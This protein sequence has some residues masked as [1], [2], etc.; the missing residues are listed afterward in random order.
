MKYISNPWM[1]S[2]STTNFDSKRVEND[3]KLRSNRKNVRSIA[4]DY[5]L[6]FT[7]H[8]VHTRQVLSKMVQK[9]IFQYLSYFH[10]PHLPKWK[11][12][13]LNI[14][15]PDYQLVLEQTVRSSRTVLFFVMFD[16]FKVWFGPKCD[17]HK[18]S[19]FGRV[20]MWPD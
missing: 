3:L 18:C 12:F 14:R 1:F 2:S 13:F 7:D 11:Y 19:K 4:A 9:N 8:L 10:G 15:W 20:V 16:M 6:V 5:Y 17:V